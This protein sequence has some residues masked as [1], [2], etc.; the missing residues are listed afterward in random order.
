[1]LSDDR[2]KEEMEGE[3][4]KEEQEDYPWLPVV[5]PFAPVPPARTPHVSPG[6]GMHDTA[7]S[8]DLKEDV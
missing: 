4:E 3:E 6:R 8:Q 5:P 7:L 1:M 2:R